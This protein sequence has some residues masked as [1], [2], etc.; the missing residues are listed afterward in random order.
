MPDGVTSRLET[1]DLILQTLA[2]PSEMTRSHAALYSRSICHAWESESDWNK[3]WSNDQL[4]DAIRLIQ[5]A[6]TFQEQNQPTKSSRAY[7]RAGEI[8]EWLSKSEDSLIHEIPL[9]LLSGAAFQ[10]AGFPAMATALLADPSIVLVNNESKIYTAFFKAEF[11]NAATLCI[12]FWANYS[13]EESTNVGSIIRD[14]IIRSL[15]VISWAF[16]SGEKHRVHKAMSK[17]K[18]IA[19]FALSTMSPYTWLLLALLEETTTKYYGSSIWPWTESMQATVNDQGKTWL[20]QFARS[21]CRNQKPLAWPAQQEAIEKLISLESF[22][23]CTPTASGKTTV[24]QLAVLQ[25]LFPAGVIEDVFAFD[26]SAPLVMV[27]APSRALS[28][29]TEYK[30]EKTFSHKSGSI[31]ITGMYGGT[32]WSLAEVWLNQD[33]PTILICTVE[34]AEALIRYAGKHILRRLSLIVIDEAHQI[35]LEGSDYNVQS[36][37][38]GENRPARLESFASRLFSLK[39]DLRAI[40][41]S[42]V[43]FGAEQSIAAWISKNQEAKP[44]GSDYRSTRQLIGKLTVFSEKT[45]QILLERLNDKSLRLDN[46]E[47]PFIPLKFAPMPKLNTDYTY[48]LYKFNEACVLWTALNLSSQDRTILI[49]THTS[50]DSAIAHFAELLTSPKWRKKCPQFFVPPLNGHKLAI[51]KDCLNAVMDFCGEESNE[52]KLVSQ[53]VAVHYGQLPTKLRQLMVKIIDEGIMPITIATSTL[54]EGVNLPFDI[55]LMPRTVRTFYDYAAKVRQEVPLT[56]S[57]FKNL[58]G[59]AGR[60]GT[61][62]EGMTLIAVPQEPSSKARGKQKLLKKQLRKLNNQYEVLIESL[63]RPQPS[64]LPTSPFKLLISR[65]VEMVSSLLGVHS[66]SQQV[67]EWLEKTALPDDDADLPDE[68]MHLFS[69]LDSLDQILL[70]SI[71]EAEQ[72][73]QD[74]AYAEIEARLKH[75]WSNTFARYVADNQAS[76]ERIFVKRGLVLQTVIYPDKRERRKLYRLGLRPAKGRAFLKVSDDIEAILRN[77]TQYHISEDAKR[78]QFFTTII[79]H[80]VHT[81]A[82]T[83]STRFKG[84]NDNWEMILAWWLQLP[85]SVGPEADAVRKWLGFACENFEYRASVAIEGVLSLVWDRVCGE[86]EAQLPSLKEWREKTD[87]P[88]IAFWCSELLRWG[89][90]NPLTAFLLSTRDC[91]NRVA[92]SF[93]SAAYEDWLSSRNIS[94]DESISPL[95]IKSWHD[96]FSKNKLLEFEKDSSIKKRKEFKV[97]LL[98]IFPPNTTYAVFPA[99]VKGKI[100]WFDPAGY[101]LAECVLDETDYERKHVLTREARLIPDLRVVL[102]Q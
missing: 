94:E 85:G 68:M 20:N 42:A 58:A 67:E 28:A 52:Y 75:I 102:L 101:L 4:D 7:R 86:D 87:L 21:A 91:T 40:A 93:R 41:L 29:E 59:R 63:E 62:A 88:W 3:A 45:G 26:L 54:T 82:I 98:E 25:G 56:A 83:F 77:Q 50:I 14:D 96:E 24:S 31:Q 71:V 19:S 97:Q 27:L 44:V 84:L 74:I 36:L 8:L 57:E 47:P 15:G 60:P 81:K 76:L 65:I 2:N 5:A 39:P 35:L 16:H 10:I 30:M 73:K 79:S 95:V 18:L 13:D 34:K 72:E 99:Y 9:A 38:D 46:G 80:L 17:L 64:L 55:I 23:M 33:K 22:A 32:E 69:A 100:L 92:A 11:L 89:T 48:S 51:Y 49:S 1:A 37:V 90:L 61:R 78:L 53:G 12:D 70:S 66:E 6:K 43:A